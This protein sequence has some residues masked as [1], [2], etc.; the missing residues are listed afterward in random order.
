MSFEAIDKKAIAHS[1]GDAAPRYDSVAHF[2]RFVGE[3]LLS[4]LPENKFVSI[5]DLGTGTGYFLKSLQDL[6]KESEVVAADLSEGML[7]FVQETYISGEDKLDVSLVAC[8]A[9]N[10]PFI[11]QSFD[12][13]FSSLAVQ[14]CYD[15]PKLFVEV[16][17]ILKPKGVFAY[18]TLLEG[19]LRELKQSWQKVD[20]AQHVND[21][22]KRPR[23]TAAS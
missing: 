6:S 19:S 8:D 17:R 7:H 13:V 1:F 3:E 5:L 9:E 2:Q 14:W 15:L 16:S 20:Q 11:P 18:S 22:S 23:R 12:L 10:L 4:R 21:L